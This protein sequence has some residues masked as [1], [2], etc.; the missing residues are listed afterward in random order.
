MFRGYF[1]EFTCQEYLAHGKKVSLE[2]I[3]IFG[4]EHPK[5]TTAD[6]DS[7]VVCALALKSMC[8]FPKNQKCPFIFQNYSFIFQKCPCVSQKCLFI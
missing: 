4:F 3:E 5:M 6:K 2:K 7:E 8:L 1:R